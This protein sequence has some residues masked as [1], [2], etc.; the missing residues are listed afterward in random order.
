MT[1]QVGYFI[2]DTSCMLK[3]IKQIHLKT[4]GGK[5]RQKKRAYLPLS[6]LSPAN[7]SM[8]TS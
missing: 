5:K 3:F 6:R 2:Y 7:S 1:F 8:V 4:I